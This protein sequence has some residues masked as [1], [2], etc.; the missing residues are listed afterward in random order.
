MFPL[1]LH[2]KQRGTQSFVIQHFNI[3][4]LSKAIPRDIK[5][6]FMKVA[7]DLNFPKIIG[8]CF[9]FRKMQSSFVNRK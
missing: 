5:N 1:K 7:T 4:E 6:R 2:K 9:V 8:L 3:G